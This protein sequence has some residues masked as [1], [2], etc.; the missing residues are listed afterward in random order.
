MPSVKVAITLESETLKQLDRLVARQIF[1]NRSRAIQA[2]VQ[3]KLTR[4][5]GS[6][7]EIESAKFDIAEE[8]AL[9]EEGMSAEA[10]EWPKY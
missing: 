9:A 10:S 5:G 3:E 6:R 4:I 8:Q 2:A 1:P 7:L